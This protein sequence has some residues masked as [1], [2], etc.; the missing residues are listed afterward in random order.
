VA[1]SPVAIK[2]ALSLVLCLMAAGCQPEPQGTST[3]ISGPATL[4]APTERRGRLRQRLARRFPDQYRDSIELIWG[5]DDPP[6]PQDAFGDVDATEAFAYFRGRSSIFPMGPRLLSCAVVGA[7]GNLRGSGF[8][9]E[10]DA[11]DVVMRIN[12]APTHGFEED[13]G[14]R[15]THYLVTQLVLG[16]ILETG[17]PQ[18]VSRHMDERMA[19]LA[20]GASWLLVFRPFDTDRVFGELLPQVQKLASSSS[21]P[22]PRARS[23]LVH[24]EF[25]LHVAAEWKTGDGDP[26]T[27]LIGVLFAVHT[28][29]T[30]G[31]YG[32]GPDAA[33]RRS[34][35]YKP[36]THRY[37]GPR[38]E[39]ALL[40]RLA[41]AS[42]I[43]W[44]VPGRTRQ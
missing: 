28:C 32:F 8:G 12:L 42:V 22:V 18:G 5:P 35:Y 1:S 7:S 34:Y 33:G 2:L 39:E 21:H 36:G 43:D 40:G 20:S 30:V 23:R 27:G 24:P 10:I 19:S 44:R 3:V 14:G 13:V 6:L 15:T 9:R 17:G 31:V 37:H 29:D 16:T 41:A 11:H 38:G 25:T 26:S 4:S